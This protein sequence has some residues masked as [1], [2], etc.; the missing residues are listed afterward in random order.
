MFKFLYVLRS[1]ESGSGGGDANMDT[2]LNKISDLEIRIKNVEDENA[3]LKK[4]N[5]QIMSFN[6]QLLDRQPGVVKSNDKS[7]DEAKKELDKYLKGE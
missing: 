6:R 4:Q 1:P 5:E 7:D 3:T 2:L